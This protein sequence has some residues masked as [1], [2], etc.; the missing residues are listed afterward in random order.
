MAKPHLGGQGSLPDARWL[1]PQITPIEKHRRRN[2]DKNDAQGNDRKVG[3]APGISLAFAA[4]GVARAPGTV[5]TSFTRGSGQSCPV[6]LLGGQMLPR[7]AQFNR[8][9]PGS[10]D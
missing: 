10:S 7:K 6:G 8:R 5:E 1:R 2:A 9:R 4:A 3:S